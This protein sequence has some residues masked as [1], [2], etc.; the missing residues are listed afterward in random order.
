MGL[1]FK[2]GQ[3]VPEIRGFYCSKKGG[4]LWARV[5]DAMEAYFCYL[6]TLL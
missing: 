2:F 3:A 6:H 4:F 1:L 5:K